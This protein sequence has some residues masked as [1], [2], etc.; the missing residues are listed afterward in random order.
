MAD[1][2]AAVA[3]PP[4]APATTQPQQSAQTTVSASA[5]PA[6][7]S[8]APPP[9]KGSAA[10]R[11]FSDLRAKA[12][13]SGSP[14]EPAKPAAT[15]KASATAP[16]EA[17]TESA[18]PAPAAP[19]EG[20]PPAA[21]AT[22]DKKKVNP[23]K[24]VDTYKA[25]VA[26]LEKQAA[27]RAALPP[28]EKEQ[29]EQRL[30][31]AT[32]R[33]NE[34]EGEMRL[35]NYEKTQEFQDKYQ[36][37]YDAAWVRAMKEVNE[38]PV[39]N[40]D[41]TP[42]PATAQDLLS[43]VNLPLPQAKELARQMFGDFADDVMGFRKEIR[44][45]YDSQRQA[46]EDAKKGGAEHEKQQRENMQ[47]FH[48]EAGKHIMD[49]W[50]QANEEMLA[51]EKYGR[52]FKPVE[53]DDE[54]NHRLDS[55]FKLAQQAFAENPRDPN[56][57][58]ERRSAIVRRHAALRN[59]AAAFGPMAA[60]IERLESKLKEAETKLSQYQ[61][62]EPETAGATTTASPGTPT[63]RDSIFAELRKRAH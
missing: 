17:P 36:K 32:D 12:K 28:E 6:P 52:F 33:L 27:E 1:A 48:A 43:L 46:I 30:K 47:K 21:A 44:G 40:E 39:L 8:P 56:L 34:L 26:E 62:S 7:A 58:P 42:R 35:T 2:P 37:P 23:W 9:K 15:K 3:A 49:T 16:A 53:G 57:T 51:H 19:E 18:E 61:G 41:G 55:G 31:A 59:R 38:I 60:R 25:K 4:A 22:E 10:D 20:A 54:L 63:A 11:M 24:V 29:Y 50:K 5:L 13:P 14:D 45:L